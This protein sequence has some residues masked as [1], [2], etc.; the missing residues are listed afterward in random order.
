MSEITQVTDVPTIDFKP[1]I[2]NTTPSG[3]TWKWLQTNL[4]IWSDER[5]ETFELRV[6]FLGS[7]RTLRGWQTAW[8]P[9]SKT[10]IPWK[11]QLPPDIFDAAVAALKTGVLAT[12]EQ[13]L[14]KNNQ[15]NIRS[16]KAA[17]EKFSADPASLRSCSAADAAALVSLAEFSSKRRYFT[18][19]VYETFAFV[20][21]EKLL[22]L[23][24]PTGPLKKRNPDLVEDEDGMADD[25]V[26]IFGLPQMLQQSA[27]LVLEGV[28]GTGKTHAITGLR[29]QLD[30]AGQPKPGTGV[31]VMTACTG[32][33]LAVDATTNAVRVEVRFMTMHPSTSYE[34]FVEGLRPAGGTHNSG[35]HRS[36]RGADHENWFFKS[37]DPPK[38]GFAVKN[39]FFVEAC[40]H[41]VDNPDTAVIVVLDELNRCN[42]PK[43]LGDLMTVIEE[44][45]RA[46]WNESAQSWVVDNAAKAVTLP[47][48]GRK[49]F[50]PD[51]I[52]IVGTMNT[53]D[54][55]VAPMD[56]ALRRRFAFHRVWPDGFS[57]S[58]RRPELTNLGAGLQESVIKTHSELWLA[59]NRTL[60]SKFGADAM[61]GH[62]YLYDLRTAL[63]LD[64]AKADEVASYHWNHRIL[65]QLMDVIESNG[66]TR[67]LVKD[68][69]TFFEVGGDSSDAAIIGRR[70]AVFFSG[71]SGFKKPHLQH[72]G[73]L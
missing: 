73:T 5:Q 6:S 9:D 21:D 15:A 43:V 69:S 26:L 61:L 60:F 42:I 59:I 16:V 49:L 47:Y 65:P 25:E 4:P 19:F 71:D 28:P 50:V 10:G 20:H 41:A 11:V 63:L 8:T 2:L 68:P 57:P 48:S 35:S 44:S 51:N 29:Q 27:N 1:T 30:E 13:S 23:Y 17:I 67:H 33:R 7:V 36:V 14:N 18:W 72:T 40:V 45:K 55:S 32:R 62:S 64:S 54:R 53:T 70:I 31:E 52:F 58:S 66:L 34:D 46:N 3:G 24:N 38:A 12:A 22:Q 56:A 39:G 37:F